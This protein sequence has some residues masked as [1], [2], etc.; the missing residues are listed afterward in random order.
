MCSASAH[1]YLDPATGSAL[2][3]GLIAVVAGLLFTLKLYWHRLLGF[4]GLNKKKDL[5][6]SDGGS[7]ERSPSQ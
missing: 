7:D 4:F 1:A 5:P 3:Q 2:I 6:S